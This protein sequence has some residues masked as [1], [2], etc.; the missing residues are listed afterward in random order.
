M[1][2]APFYGAGLLI[3]YH[4]DTA[5]G[6]VLLAASAAVFGLLLL[7]KKREALCAFGMAA[8]A[9]AMLLVQALY[10][11]PLESFCGSTVETEFTIS[12]VLSSGGDNA[13]Y[14]AET[15][16]DGRSTQVRLSAEDCLR[17][18]D[19]V[20]A[21]V[22][23]R[24]R[25]ENEYYLEN[26]SR[27]I[28]LSGSAQN[29]GEV[30]RVLNSPARVLQGLRDSLMSRVRLYIGG[31]ESALAMAMLFGDSSEMS[32]KLREASCVS[33][34]SH[35]TAVSG[36]HFAVVCAVLIQ[37]LSGNKRKFVSA[38]LSVLII[39]L[40]LLFFGASASVLRSAIMV[41][42]CSSAPLF[43]R[44]TVTLNS[45]CA[46]F[47]VITAVNPPAVLDAG[48]QMS[49][50]GVLGVSAGDAVGRRLCEL[51]PQRAIKLSVPVRAASVSA[52]AVVL[53]SPVSISCFGGISLLGAP[54][55][56]L[57]IPLF[58]AAMALV[59]VMG[60]TGLPII[61]AP[62]ALVLRV[63]LRIILFFGEYRWLW[64]PMSFRGAAL[65]AGVCAALFLA[66][67][68]MR[69][70][71]RRVLLK[72]FTGM[73]CFMLTMCLGTRYSKSCVDF[74]SDGTSGAAVVC[75]RSEAVVLISGNGNRLMPR[76]AECLRKNGAQR[77]VLAADGLDYCGALAAAELAEIIPT[78]KIYTNEAAREVLSERCG[79]VLADF[80]ADSISVGEFVIAADKAG[81]DVAA[82]V[83]L[84]SGYLRKAPDNN[85]VMAVYCS[86]KQND[87]PENG[88]N[89]YDEKPL[90]LLSGVEQITINERQT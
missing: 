90:I 11:T 58:T 89:I 55:S 71:N 9:A 30:R 46:A 16:L 5:A 35:F 77:I 20:T 21:Q 15:T 41:F 63:M 67:A 49:V 26:L 79:D 18:G 59:L 50:L 51:L 75:V 72:C 22:T 31:D 40:A 23:F 14:L 12:E 85:A 25:A 64:L 81:G 47:L 80:S 88:T 34:V 57:I 2:L 1:R 56:P 29:L 39:P 73:S 52:G 28:M 54:V 19:T 44:Q 17:T 87:L 82:D 13:V 10:F 86:S 45:L 24:E 78:E 65:G 3:A 48:F 74:V 27:G 32:L 37:L 69:G 68:A 60:I 7:L 62:L 53:T 33:G 84:Y 70:D 6:I 83:V 66:A 38:T 8:G 4:A 61:A 42:L 76:L 36:A 43:H